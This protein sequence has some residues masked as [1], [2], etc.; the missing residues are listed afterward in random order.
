MFGQIITLYYEKEE[1]LIV[2][3]LSLHRN[4]LTKISFTLTDAG[5]RVKPD[6]ERERE[7]EH[8]HWM[9]LVR[10]KINQNNPAHSLSLLPETWK[11]KHTCERAFPAA[12]FLDHRVAAATRDD[13]GPLKTDSLLP[14]H[15]LL[16]LLGG[17]NYWGRPINNKL[18]CSPAR[19]Y[20]RLVIEAYRDGQSA[21]TCVCV[22]VYLRPSEV[23]I[24][25]FFDGLRIKSCERLR[26][27]ERACTYTHTHTMRWW[28]EICARD[29]CFR[30]KPLF[31]LQILLTTST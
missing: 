6:A 28:W 8:Y 27:G 21:C 20:T 17:Y 18:A 31:F 24:I 26:R 7:R 2:I 13:R 10:C 12:D 30:Y 14:H 19:I 16:L 11:K 3:I 15:L 22:C 23:V 1:K 5:K 25:K 4:L 9:A 29:S